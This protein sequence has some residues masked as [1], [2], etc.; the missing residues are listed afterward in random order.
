M[1][2]LSG[3]YPRT[4]SAWR[5]LRDQQGDLLQGAIEAGLRTDKTALR[6]LIEMFEVDG[7]D[8]ISRALILNSR[9]SLSVAHS[10]APGA[11]PLC[12]VSGIGYACLKT[13]IAMGLSGE[14]LAAPPSCVISP[15]VLSRMSWQLAS[16]QE[17]RKAWSAQDEDLL[18][19]A[20]RLWRSS[21]A[22]PMSTPATDYSAGGA[23]E[24]LRACPEAPGAERHIAHLMALCG[25]YVHHAQ[26]VQAFDRAG[27][28]MSIFSRW[29]VS[30]KQPDTIEPCGIW[31]KEAD[32]N[33]VLPAAM[34]AQH[35]LA[36][37]CALLRHQNSPETQNIVN[38]ITCGLVQNA[39]N[40]VTKA[41]C[42]M[43]KG[44]AQ[45]VNPQMGV[46]MLAFL[47]EL[48]RQCPSLM[49]QAAQVAMITQLFDP[50]AEKIQR[51]VS[52]DDFL[53]LPGH[54]G[55]PTL[56][57]AIAQWPEQ[58]GWADTT[59]AGNHFSHWRTKIMC[60]FILGA[61]S[62]NCIAR[63][64]AARPILQRIASKQFMRICSPDQVLTGACDMHACN[65]LIG[66]DFRDTLA[67]LSEVG[68]DLN[69]PVDRFCLRRLSD[70]QGQPE[71]TKT[72]LHFMAKKGHPDAIAALSIALEMGC[73][74]QF[75]G[76]VKPGD[77]IDNRAL[78]EKW[79]ATMRSHAARLQAQDAIAQINNEIS[80]GTAVRRP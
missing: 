42:T 77:F 5:A 25:R 62:F 9:T 21:A 32:D 4:L 16:L 49:T 45:Q 76:D 14:D 61:A 56:R 55:R 10:L 54:Q 29:A 64:E 19:A 60:D 65:P 24:P 41:L 1:S 7:V 70:P 11:S 46:H 18:Q 48:Q 44:D 75:D 39:G 36:G 2:T 37:A 78:K 80:A 20:I 38:Q 68:F 27:V 74:P 8:A 33:I 12:G 23:F 43:S 71:S 47:D 72:I 58:A 34:V 53:N 66:P 26:A 69:A 13:A 15:Q 3:K 52:I 35:N 50:Q 17:P 67:L 28:D 59:T 57:Q 79:V 73:D 6:M 51:D 31:I 63:L 30:V 22:A 40:S